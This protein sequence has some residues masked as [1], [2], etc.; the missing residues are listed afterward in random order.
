MVTQALVRHINERRLI[1]LIRTAGPLARA[2]IARRLKLTRAAVTGVVDDLMTRG[3][4][5]ESPEPADAR[6]EV[7]RPGIAVALAPDGAYFLGIEIGVG[8]ARLA[9]I[10]LAA[11]PVTTDSLAFARTDAPQKIVA[12][13][14]AR[15]KTLL[16][17]PPWA[18][19]VRAAGITVP[20]LVR[21]DGHV[22]NLPI[23]GWRD[24]DLAPLLSAALPIPVHLENNANAGAFGHVY[25]E[26]ESGRGVMVYLKLGT[27]CGGAVILDGRLLRGA[28]GLG[29]EFGHIRI[30]ETG[31]TCSCGQI[32][33]LET[34]VNLAALARYAG[35][36]P[37]TALPL[38][39]AEDISAGR[40]ESV[41]A[42]DR[43]ADHLRDGLVTL[44]NAFNPERIVLGG[45][46][47]PL[48][49]GI[50]A[51]IGPEIARRIVP[52]MQPPR[53][54]VSRI[55]S[56]EVAIGAAAL[57][58]HAEFDVTALPLGDSA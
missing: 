9:I 48:L 1:G 12:A 13:I 45:Q 14:G 38:R 33:C 55:G 56:F 57:A 30:A 50:V 11:R 43:L 54:V 27:G 51:R 37:A 46:M 25:A 3:L 18:G 41:A 16:A 24:L 31:P 19:R 8:V 40:P 34:F 7:G 26:P 53:L 47:L 36:E 42:R 5:V 58:H 29:A 23:L 52:G 20:G 10:D 28:S 32:G 21:A 39:I 35:A 6:R 4:V 22:V 44:A 17:H 15:A 2:E 49:D